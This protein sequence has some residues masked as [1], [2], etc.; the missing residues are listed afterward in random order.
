[1]RSKRIAGIVAGAVAVMVPLAAPASSAVAASSSAATPSKG[2]S[3]EQLKQ[4]DKVAKA[5]H[6]L[7]VFAAESG[8]VL[9]LPAGTPADRKAEALGKA[10]KVLDA[11]TVKVSKFT[12]KELDGLGKDILTGPWNKN[13]SLVTIEYDGA[14]DKMIVNTDAPESDRTGLAKAHGDKIKVRHA[15]IQSQWNRFDDYA[16]FWGGTSLMND[17]SVCTSGWGLRNVENQDNGQR[18]DM[19]T[20]AGH[21][22]SRHDLIVNRHEDWSSGQWMGWVKHTDWN[23]DVEAFLGYRYE[24]QIWTG[25][26]SWANDSRPVKGLGG[27]WQGLTVSVSGQ[28]TFA[29]GNHTITADNY[30]FT[31]RSEDGNQHYT[32]NGD[33]FAYAPGSNWPSYDQ[34]MHTEVGDSGAPIYTVDYNGG[35]YAV[36]S[37]SGMVQWWEGNCGCQQYRMYGVKM[38][39]VLGSWGASL[40]T[41]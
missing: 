36:G 38:G 31:W 12:Q 6:A 25:S 14:T 34:G 18:V 32:W 2:P 28:T 3:Q 8:P 26:Y 39:S 7:G 41:R 29:H 21:C 33:G 11:T 35:A 22:F 30:G 37:H 13:D 4:I 20:T 17:L 23:L 27:L 15:R 10:A 5:E 1:M 19:M 16:P 9:V 24:G 40:M